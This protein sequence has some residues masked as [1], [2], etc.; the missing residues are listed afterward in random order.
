MKLGGKT[1]L[2]CDCAG[3]MPLDGAALAKACGAE[4]CAVSTLLCR[5]QIGKVQKAAAGAESGLLIACT[6]EGAAFGEALDEAGIDLSPDLV[7]IRE[8]AGW[9]EEGGKALPKIA[10][11][12]AEAALDPPDVPT[13]EMES[14][15]I[16]LV[17]GDGQTAV[18]A[19]KQLDGRMTVSL[20]LRD[21]GEVLPLAMAE[22][23]TATG[24][25][26]AAS[27]HL[28]DF[29]ISVDGYAALDPASR[30]TLRFG[31]PTNGAAA[32][33]DVILDLTGAPPLVAHADRRDGYL[34]ADPADPAAVQKA[35][36]EASDLV[37]TFEKPRYVAAR[38]ELCAHSRS[39]IIGCTRCLDVCP[40]GA[41]RPDGDHVAI[42]PYLCG[43][44]GSC[45]SVCPTQSASYAYPSDQVLLERTAALLGAYR[46]AG[47]T[48][49][50]LLI[51]A[52]EHGRGLI[53]AS[54]RFGRGLPARVIPMAVHETTQLNAEFLLSA[55]AHGAER[56]VLLAA[57]KRKTELDGLAQQL[58]LVESLLT[59]LGYQS[60]L[61]SLEIADDPDRL[62]EVLWSLPKP[63]SG[64]KRPPATF[65]PQPEK[66]TNM[67][68]AAEHLRKHAPDAVETVS[69]PP[70]SAFGRVAVDVEGCTLCLACVGACPTNALSDN[71]DRPQ[72]SFQESACI[73][74][75][76]CKS[77]CPEKVIRLE[78]RYRFGEKAND[79][80]VVK[81]EEPFECISCG[82]PFAAKSTIEKM[83]EKLGDKHWMFQGAGAD[84]LKMCEDCRVEAVF[85]ENDPQLASGRRPMPRTTDDY[86]N[87]RDRGEDD[88]LN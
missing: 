7:N 47:G 8:R 4:S 28:G 86:L 67:R 69:L 57:E 36:Y 79:R 83:L 33:C 15:G 58:G 82:K 10:A 39:R 32:K 17:Y 31:R 71:P 64:A 24:R 65:L 70:G 75:G 78:P 63:K 23:M 19:A 73:Q 13:V 76:L 22:I 5:D 26:A 1:V 2:V 48:R 62:E 18:D 45:N 52:D 11:L 38:P 9:S 44:C 37:G 6:Q 42:D 43:G 34:R 50:V 53:E 66:R 59:A 84:R 68:L 55:L 41:I 12:L 72:L 20:L 60:G 16:C 85:N 40:A 77:T 80:E 56:I 74:C 61:I 30:N 51:H 35:I 87:A 3:T 88:A 49:P 54:A 14:T 25:I 29:E 21:P 81:E 46:E 27:G